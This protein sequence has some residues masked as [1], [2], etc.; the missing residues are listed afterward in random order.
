MPKF[1][2]NGQEIDAKS[3][4][5]IIQAADDHG[6]AIPHYC[7]HKDLPIDGNC[8]MCL[9]DV[10]KMPKLTP[11]CTTIVNEGMVVRSDNERVKEAV[12]GVLEFLLINH[13]VDCP[14]CDQA[15]ECRLQDYYMVYGLHTSEI[16]LEMKVRKRKVLET[17]QLPA[18]VTVS[19]LESDGKDR[20]FCGGGGTGKFRAVRRP[21]R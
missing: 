2:L 12:R 19:G 9:V 4:Q 1:N 18:G 13:P 5:T 7:Y 10:E 8:R 21:K 3:G 14:V 17:L 15:G 20:F 16:P 11:A 6:V